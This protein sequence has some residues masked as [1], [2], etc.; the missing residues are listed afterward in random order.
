[1]QRAGFRI[2][3]VENAYL[4]IVRMIEAANDGSA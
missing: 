4:D 1:V 2:V 3:R